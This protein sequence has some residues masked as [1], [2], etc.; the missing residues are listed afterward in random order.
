MGSSYAISC[1][2]CDYKK[3]FITGIGMMY[4][5]HNLTDFEA[6]NPLLPSLIRSERSVDFIKALL[7]NKDAVI[8]DSYSHEIY[9]CPKCGE[10]YGRFFIQL[11]YYD[12]GSFEVE[13]KCPKC[14]VALK[15]IEYDAF[16]DDVCEDK[17][18]SLEKYPCRPKCGKHSLFEGGEAYVLW[19]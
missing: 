6:D 5:P 4:A 17:R 16:D 19:N 12:G 7:A 9:R 1:K 8:A 2:S 10:F 18:I 14:K 15:P 13:Y 11:D 3:S